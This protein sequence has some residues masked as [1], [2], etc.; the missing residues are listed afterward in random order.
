MTT[1]NE[2]LSTDNKSQKA[3]T[4]KVNT[5]GNFGE[6]VLRH[7]LITFLIAVIV[8]LSLWVFIKISLLENKFKKDTLKL[9]SDYENKIDS[10][11]TNQ[12]MLSSKVFSWAIRSELTRENKEQVN[13]FFLNFIKEPGVGKVEF[14]N[15][16]DGRVMLSTNKKDEGSAFPNQVALATTETINYKND[17]VLSI[18]S[19]VMGLNNKLGVLVIEYNLKQNH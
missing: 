7:K 5:K 17:S 6:L 18:V 9:K 1:E 14:V 10:L 8:I 2:K 16:L 12:L 13:Q 19:P 15:A 11:T 3:S 4:D